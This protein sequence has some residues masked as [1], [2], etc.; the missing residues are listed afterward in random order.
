MASSASIRT[1]TLAPSPIDP[2]APG[3]TVALAR[4]GTSI[5]LLNTDPEESPVWAVLSVLVSEDPFPG[6]TM[7]GHEMIWMKTYSENK[8]LFEQLERAGWIRD[9]TR[10]IQ[11]G[12]ATLP[13]VEIRLEETEMAHS[14]GAC[15]TFEA[16]TDPVRFKRCSKCK[17][18]Y[19][20]K[21]DDWKN[22]KMDCKDLATGKQANV[23]NRRRQE[24]NSF[25]GGSGFQTFNV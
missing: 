5:I 3:P 23:E 11:Q 2:T 7:D 20:C 14:C 25:L 15:E 21:N 8:G 6:Y 16:V 13:C 4:Q 17:K 24:V 1:L 22:H 12:Y 18:V 19:Y 10:K 9:S